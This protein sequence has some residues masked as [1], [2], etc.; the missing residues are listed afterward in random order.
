MEVDGAEAQ[1]PTQAA[2]APPTGQQESRLVISKMVLENFKSYYGVKTIG[3][4]H[5]V[6]KRS[7]E[8]ISC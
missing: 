7:A 6:R 4:M 8:R 3:P 2:A 5:K 1:M